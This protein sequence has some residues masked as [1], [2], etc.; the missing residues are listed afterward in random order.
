MEGGPRRGDCP[1]V[2]L[3]LRD[4]TQQ[5]G[6]EKGDTGLPH[7]ELALGSSLKESAGEAGHPHGCGPWVHGLCG[8]QVSGS[9]TAPL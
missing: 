7:C 1:L 8:S 3:Q 2:H 4:C 5:W 6:K 9:R